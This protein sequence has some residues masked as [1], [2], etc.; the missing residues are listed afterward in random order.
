ME[1]LKY[2]EESVIK[3]G[4][5][6]VK[7]L[8]LEDSNNT[9]ARWMAHYI[10]G[11][12]EKINL[13]TSEE[14]RKHLQQECCDLIL[15]L[16]SKKE[17]LPIVKPLDNLKPLIE[18]LEVLKEEKE[19]SISPRWLEYH[20]MPRNNE[21]A[22]FVETVKNNSE[23]TFNKVAQM[24]MHKD[25]LLKDKE[26]MKENKEFLTQEE[27]DF[28]SVA[29]VMSKFYKSLGVVDLNNFDISDDNQKRVNEMFD[30]LEKLIDDQKE[31]LQKVRNKFI[32]N[33]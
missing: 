22:S 23:I 17:D 28:L 31:S 1:Q 16:W 18:I 30:D 32:K 10:A 11:L 8:N 20:S 3:L 6:L 9:L 7:E 5:K 13:A 24:N 2:S 19:V 21:W 26:W 29:D 12:I 25:I 14:N 27:K 33:D 4:E 15:K